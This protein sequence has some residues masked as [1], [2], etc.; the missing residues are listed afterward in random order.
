MS[1]RDYY[2]VLGLGKGA[3]SDEI[4]KAYR[5][6]AVK[7]HPDKNPDDK[8]SEEKFKEVGEAYEALSDPEKKSAYDQFG[9]AAFNPRARAGRGGGGF[10]DP[11]DIFREA[12]SGAGGGGGGG[13]F[14]DLFGGGGQR[15]SSG[16]TRGSDLRYDMELSFQEAVHGC[17]K[18]IKLSK[19]DACESCNGS[20][21][22]D[23]ARR[24][25]CDTCNG[26]GQ[27]VQSQGFFSVA[28]TCPRCHGSG[29]TIDK[30][31]PKCNGDG[32]RDKSSKVT[33]RVPAGVS[34]GARLRSTGNG[35]AGVYGGKP[36]DLYVML[37]VKDHEVF[38]RDG[39]DLQCEVP[40]SFL[41]ATLGS[42]IEVPTLS[43]SARINV[44][45]GTQSATILRLR[46]KGVK[47]VQGYGHGDL[48][49]R[50]IV[51]VPTRLNAKQKAK[52]TEFGELCD[53]RVNPMRSSFSEKA[54]KF[55]S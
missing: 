5:K 28:Q 47:N 52:L 32:R 38:E 27:V 4:K 35:E 51:E 1:K 48:H 37:H 39:D 29:S 50:V 16:P 31:C 21:A 42:E 44:P 49:V 9:H 36:G 30:P 2:E 34:T 7:Y 6:L 24:T 18:E 8:V 41:Q 55:F 3:S 19:L 20:G 14:E 17:E 26:R 45:P 40:I 10:Q 15:S 25:T 54:K 22:T 13:I 46:G 23:G 11:F 33:I 53:D 43:G 12:F